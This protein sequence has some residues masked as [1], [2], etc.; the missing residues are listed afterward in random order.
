MKKN[1]GVAIAKLFSGKEAMHM[2]GALAASHGPFAWGMD[3][4]DAVHNA[5]VMEELAKMAFGTL[6]A[7]AGNRPDRQGINGQTF[8]EK[9][10]QRAQ[11]TGRKNKN[12]RL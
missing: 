2:P 3:A 10:W 11:P 6:F 1:T 8:P 5:V 9:A 7:F 4:A 12:N